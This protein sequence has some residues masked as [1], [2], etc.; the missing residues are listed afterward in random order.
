MAGQG[1]PGPRLQKREGQERPKVY[2][3]LL[4]FKSELLR[5]WVPSEGA[6]IPTKDVQPNMPPLKISALP[7]LENEG[8]F[9]GGS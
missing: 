9:G 6:G 5:G 2:S 8:H 3:S 7:K 4:A 1:S